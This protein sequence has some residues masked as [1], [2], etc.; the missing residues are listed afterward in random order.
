VRLALLPRFVVLRRNELG[1]EF[2]L[3]VR[4]FELLINQPNAGSQRADVVAR[5]LD[6]PGCN[7]QRLLFQDA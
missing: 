4:G 5:R 7:R 2:Q 3:V 1:A 6:H